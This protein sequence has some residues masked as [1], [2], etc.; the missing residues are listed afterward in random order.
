MDGTYFLEKFFVENLFRRGSSVVL[1][2]HRSSPS[3]RKPCKYGQVITMAD[4][5]K[6]LKMICRVF[7]LPCKFTHLDEIGNNIPNI[8]FSTV[9]HVNLW[10]KEAFKHHFFVRFARAFPFLRRLSISNIRPPS[11]WSSGKRHLRLN[12]WPSIV[13][14]PHLISLDI[15][16]VIPIMWNI[17]SMKQKHVYLV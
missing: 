17:F 4:Y 2:S 15:E 3:N 1:A 10:D 6:P 12:A 9:T 8:V 14:Y 16:D 7:S 5:F 13:E 11:W